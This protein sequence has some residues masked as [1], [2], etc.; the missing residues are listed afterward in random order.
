MYIGVFFMFVHV[1]GFGVLCEHFPT[2]LVFLIVQ[3]SVTPYVG[4]ADGASRSTRNLSSTAWVIY[5]PFSELIDLQGIFLGWTTKNFAEYSD[6]LELLTEA[7]NLGIHT[8]LV[9]LDSQLGVLQLNNHYSV[10]N[11]H[12]LRLYLRI[13]LLER[14]FD[15]ITYQHIPR[16]I[17]TLTDTVANIV[18][19]R[20]LHNL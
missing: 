17:N 13:R 10:R 20:H 16:R 8:F 12:I 4:F 14:H 3:M 15:F 5:D 7:I 19:D 6:V 2:Y 18:L 1:F 9:N 11:P